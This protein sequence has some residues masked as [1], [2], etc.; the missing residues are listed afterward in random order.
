MDRT[1]FSAAVIASDLN[2]DIAI[3]K[4]T[5]TLTDF[6]VISLGTMSDVVVGEQAMAGGFPAG[7]DL[8]GPVSF[9]AGIIS[10][11]RTYNGA[12]YIQFDASFSPGNSGGC[13]GHRKW[14]N[15]RNSHC[16]NHSTP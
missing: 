14:K 9:T 3:I 2:Q 8:P 1:I 13:P 11:L 5:T 4:L 10:A 6:P 16:G 15:D 7:M 12:N